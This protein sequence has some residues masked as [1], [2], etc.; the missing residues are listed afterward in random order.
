MKKY[1]RPD[2][3]YDAMNVDKVVKKS[4]RISAL[5]SHVGIT[6]IPPI[7]TYICSQK[8]PNRNFICIG[9]VECMLSQSTFALNKLRVFMGLAHG[10]I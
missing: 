5:W 4:L 7:P 3:L 8:N 2:V 6:Y 1:I 10:M 9:L